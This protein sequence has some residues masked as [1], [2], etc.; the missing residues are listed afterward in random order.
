MTPLNNNSSN[1]GSLSPT[2]KQ[3]RLEQVPTGMVAGRDVTAYNQNQSS[4]FCLPDE[5][6]TKIIHY[7]GFREITR[8]A[9]VCKHLRDLVEN[10]KALERAWYRQLP[11]PLQYQLKTIATTKDEQQLRDWLKPFANKDAVESLVKQ[12]KS[13]YF[14]ALLF[15]NNSKLMSQSETFNLKT[16]TE[17]THL[18]K[19]S[20]AT[21]S[22]DSR[23]LVTASL[24]DTVK[25]CSQE[26][27]GSWAAK[28]IINCDTSIKSASFSADAR[29]LLVVDT[30]DVATIYGQK[31]DGPLE[32]KAT[33][34]DRSRVNW[35]C[36]SSD[37]RHAL[38]YIG[39]NTL[40]ICAQEA[41]GSWEIKAIIIHNRVINSATFSEDC[42]HLAT[43][44]Y[45]NT[46]KICDL[47]D[48][49]SW[50]EIA[51][52]THDN[53]VCSVDFSADGRHLVSISD[54]KTAKIFS[55]E[56]PG[57]WVKKATIEHNEIIATAS[58][59]A[60]GRHVV[61]TS[62]DHKVRITELWKNSSLNFHDKIESI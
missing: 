17:M 15:F 28:Y 14:P 16:K 22:A 10:H 41:T 20:V 54:D 62:E 23:H 40:K 39:R 43:A 19:I 5:I 7:L 32:A 61:T 37:G 24:D 60:D 27:D 13:T 29:H 9:E 45:D 12:Q 31:D 2:P 48:D 11:S 30:S 56:S 6:K 36:L 25:I 57:S 50:K 34:T 3:P 8:L 53:F 51:T 55:Q 35:G 58:F 49:G 42:Q 26:T 59:S 4:F 1:D 38:F 44:S 52:V 33:I 47:Q 21:L 46:A 18:D